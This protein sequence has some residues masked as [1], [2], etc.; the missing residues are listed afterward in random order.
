MLENSKL[1]E[2]ELKRL[3][4]LYKLKILDSP[5]ETLF[6]NIT[7]VASTICETPISLIS[8]IDE[9]RQWFKSAH[10][11]EDVRETPRDQAFCAHTI[12]TND[13]MEVPNALID[14]RFKENPLVLDAPAIRFYAGAPIT[15]PMGER[16]GTL[17]VIDTSPRKLTGTQLKALEGL[18]KVVSNC[19]IMQYNLH[20]QLDNSVES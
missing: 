2:T 3:K 7:K 1:S 8:L 15:L 18:A 12:L 17:C 11:L 19:L 14:V 13:V 16:I 4:A 10:G 6:D 9:N 20:K 5:Y